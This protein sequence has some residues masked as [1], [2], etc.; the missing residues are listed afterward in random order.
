MKL[1]KFEKYYEDGTLKCLLFRSIEFKYYGLYEFN[2]LNNAKDKS[3]LNN[4]TK[5][6]GFEIRDNKK[7]YH[8]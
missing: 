2:W 5:R 4:D 8:I 1:K 7:H 6:I 3:Y